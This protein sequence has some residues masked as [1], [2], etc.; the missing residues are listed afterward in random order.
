MEF[1]LEHGATLEDRVGA[2][3]SGPNV[4][5]LAQQSPYLNPNHEVIQYLLELD[6]SEL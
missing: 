3:N 2:D 5:E 1:L 6:K 4:L